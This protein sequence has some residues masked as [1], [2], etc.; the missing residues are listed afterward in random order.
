MTTINIATDIPSQI[1]TL[2][3]LNAWTAY[4]LFALNPTITVIEGVGYTERAAQ[5]NKYW[6]AA[7]AKSR[8]ISRISLEVSPDELSGSAKP[9]M[10]VQ[11]LSGTPLPSSFKTN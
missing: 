11:T 3:Q 7:D 2:E 6:V 5:C 1:T 8:L 10:Y 9:W 4:A